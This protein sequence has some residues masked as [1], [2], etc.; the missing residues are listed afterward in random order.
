LIRAFL[1]SLPLLALSFR[2]EGQALQP[3]IRFDVVGPPPV[4]LEPGV[5][6]TGRIGSYVRG[7]VAVGYD[8]RGVDHRAGERWRFDLTAR[9]TLDP[10]REQR[11]GFSFGG[12]VSHRGSA[13][14]LA[15]LL[16]LEGPEVLGLLPALQVGVSGGV[17]GAVIVRRAIRGRR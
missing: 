9:V 5:G 12:G 2:L 1:A 8:A 3:E 13:T 4:S 10:F 14:Y 15:A 7:G 17:R 11:F 16:D 6:L